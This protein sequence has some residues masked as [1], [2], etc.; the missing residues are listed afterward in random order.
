[1]NAFGAFGLAVVA[2]LGANICSIIVTALTRPSFSFLFIPVTKL[3]VNVIGH[4][5]T[6]QSFP[7]Q[8]SYAQLNE[9]GIE[10]WQPLMLVREQG[11]NAQELKA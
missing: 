2:F 9:C 3:C 8:S 1:M 10:D 11:V 7:Y 5:P 4:C 6:R